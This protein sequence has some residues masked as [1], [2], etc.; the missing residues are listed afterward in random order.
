MIDSVV[1]TNS[2]VSMESKDYEAMLRAT[3]ARMQSR[4]GGGSAGAEAA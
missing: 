2:D 1:A 4:G 3:Q